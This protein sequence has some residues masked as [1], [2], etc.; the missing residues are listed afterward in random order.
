[1]DDWLRLKNVLEMF[2]DLQEFIYTCITFFAQEIYPQS[3]RDH[4]KEG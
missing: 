2:R 3:T 4:Q 1:M